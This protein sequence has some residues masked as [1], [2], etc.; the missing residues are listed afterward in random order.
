MTPMRRSIYDQLAQ[1]MNS[2][3]FDMDNSECDPTW[4]Y[5][6]DRSTGE[7]NS[8]IEVLK[9]LGMGS[10][11]VLEVDSKFSFVNW[12]LMKEL[13]AYDFTV[14]EPVETNITHSNSTAIFVDDHDTRLEMAETMIRDNFF[15]NYDFVRTDKMDEIIF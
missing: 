13:M 7:D 5:Y 3:A 6:S 12:C 8:I 2:G 14:N 1:R 15:Y 9:A 10:F 11:E 4:H